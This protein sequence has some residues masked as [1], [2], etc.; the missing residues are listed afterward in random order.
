MNPEPSTPVCRLLCACLLPVCHPYLCLLPVCCH[1]LCP[2]CVPSL[3]L[4]CLWCACAPSRWW[5]GVPPH[6]DS[7]DKVAQAVCDKG[8]HGCTPGEWRVGDTL[9][10]LSNPH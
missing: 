1:C 4:P 8:V 3:P 7:A 9:P 10:S 6:P 5:L 2:A